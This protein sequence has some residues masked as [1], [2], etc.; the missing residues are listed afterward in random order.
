MH[1]DFRM[2]IQDPIAIAISF[3]LSTQKIDWIVYKSSGQP[4]SDINFDVIEDH[5][6][7]E[8]VDLNYWTEDP[9]RF[10][11]SSVRLPQVY[12]R[13]KRTIFEVDKV[14]L[15]CST[16]SSST[17][18]PAMS[19][20]DGTTFETAFRAST[21]DILEIQV[22]NN[23][24]YNHRANLV[25][26]LQCRLFKQWANPLWCSGQLEHEQTD[27]QKPYLRRLYRWGLKF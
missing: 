4:S 16:C 7:F 27:N 19:L 11:M 3:R 9:F 1:L 22:Q 10:D 17:N 13:Y 20:K 18:D 8:M 12:L 25:C 14:M 6:Q 5:D 2:S 21:V 23:I 24:L 26:F 15:Y